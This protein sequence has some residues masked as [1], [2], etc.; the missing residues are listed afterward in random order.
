MAADMGA[1]VIPAPRPAPLVTAAQIQRFAPACD[2]Q[3]MAP[4]L[5][6]ACRARGI[7][8]PRRLRHFLAQLHHESGGFRRLEENLN[9]TTALRLQAVWPK[10]FPTLQAAEPY[11][12]NPRALAE[13]V[14]G[15]R[16]GN[17]RPGDGWKYRGGGLIMLTGRNNYQRAQRWSG[18][19]LDDQPELLRQVGPAAEV[20][21]A[22]WQAE[23]LNE[24]VDEDDDEAAIAGVA[25]R[26][27]ANEGDDLVEATE[28]VNGGRIGL[29]DRR[30]LLIRAA[31]IWP[32]R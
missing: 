5:D 24:I 7:A 25:E 6:R 23:G 22:F 8:S 21:A 26:I 14:Y 1:D 10:R 18:L 11:I 29:E 13:K 2:F 12:R 4:A 19:P 15:G 20:A 28:E 31:F 3:A 16:L 9:Y 17:T 32:D 30:K 27:L